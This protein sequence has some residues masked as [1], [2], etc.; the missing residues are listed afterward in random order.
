MKILFLSYIIIVYGHV[1]INN[2]NDD[3]DDDNN[4]NNNYTKQRALF[5]N[6]QN[7]KTVKK[8]CEMMAYYQALNSIG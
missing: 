6:I 3:N 4:N 7:T 8:H 5:Q 1:S 2:N